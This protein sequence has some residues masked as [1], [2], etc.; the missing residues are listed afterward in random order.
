M[1]SVNHWPDS[2]CAR[3]FWSQQELRPYQELLADTA[4]WLAPV[5]GQRW[6]DLGCGCGK[7]SEVLWC[8]SG[9]TLAEI[10]GLD[11]AAVNALAFE[12]LRRRL[13]PPP[14]PEQLRFQQG[15][16]SHGLSLFPAEYFDGV[17]SGLAIQYAE[18]FSAAE[19]RWTTAAYDA[20]L[21]DIH[22][23][24]RPEGEF[25]FSVN[26]PAPAWGRVALRSLPGLFRRGKIG[27]RL[28]DAWRLYR[29]GRWL[30]REARRGRFHYLPLE[31]VLAK[32]QASGFVV[33]AQRR[34]YADQAYLFRCRKVPSDSREE[35]P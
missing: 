1:T 18:H 21:R 17:V 14:R 30:S 10:V 27:R 8:K 19:G 32:L 33:L 20:L 4:A 11:C 16:F 15:D 6:L 25:V 28:T 7:L 5:A 35:H 23:V 26:V 29:Y 22:R 13:Q 3:A 31:T 34:S 2:A 9:G 24:L 12:R